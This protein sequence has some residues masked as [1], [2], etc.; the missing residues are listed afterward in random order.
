MLEEGKEI[1][2][3][4]SVELEIKKNNKT[5]KE[6]LISYLVNNKKE[7]LFFKFIYCLISNNEVVYIGKGKN[8]RAWTFNGNQRNEQWHQYFE[9]NQIVL[10]MVCTKA[11]N[12]NKWF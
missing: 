6:S 8:D 11:Y 9:N 7:V 12:I 2:T 3:K 4:D 1:K 10:D 5:K